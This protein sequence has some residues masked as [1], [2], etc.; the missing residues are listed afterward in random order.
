[1]KIK[2]KMEKK[3]IMANKKK[4]IKQGKINQKMIVKEK[5]QNRN[6]KEIQAV[7]N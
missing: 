7:E 6:K 3:N 1:M 2:K 4:D 5:G